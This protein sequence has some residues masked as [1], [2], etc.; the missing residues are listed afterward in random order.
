MTNLLEKNLKF[1][2]KY[3][4]ELAGKILNHADLS[5][6]YEI[7]MSQSGD[8][9]IFKDSVPVDDAIDPIWSS[10]ELYSSMKDKSKKSIT[11]ILG[12][13]MGYTF[14]EFAKRYKGK[15]ILHEPNLDFLRIAFEFVDFSEELSKNNIII[16]NNS[17]DVVKAFHSLYYRGYK[18][19]FIASDYYKK[20]DIENLQKIKTE[21][22]KIYVTF[23]QTHNNL[24]NK[25]N[26]W[27]ALLFN[28]IVDIINNQDL[29]VLK[30]KFKNKTAVIISAGPSLDKNIE[31]L[32]PYRDKLIIFCVGVAFKTAVKHGIIP[33]FVSVVDN[34]KE[35]IDIPELKQVNLIVTTSINKNI[36]ELS[37]KRLYNYHIKNIPAC[38]WLGKILGVPDINEYDAAGTVA[39]NCL[40]S[41]K[42]LG[43]NKII[44]IGQDLAYTDNKCYSQ[45][46]LYAGFN[47]NQD[48]SIEFK[49]ES[50][51]TKDFINNHVKILEKDLV[52]VK[53]LDG[54]NLLTRPDYYMFKLF[55]E[56]IAK[57]LS[58]ELKLINATEGG[59]YLEGYDHITLN[60]ALEKYTTDDN[61]EPEEILINSELNLHEKAKRKK[62]FLKELDT[63]I[64]NYS[65]LKKIIISNFK[66]GFEPYFNSDHFKGYNKAELTKQIL[67]IYK[68]LAE[69]SKL[70][71][72]EHTSF[73]EIWELY[74]KTK[75]DIKAEIKKLFED[76]PELFAE[77]LKKLKDKYLLVRQLININ[78]YH[79]FSYYT[80]ILFINKLISDFDNT[81][82]EL[83][84]LSYFLNSLFYNL[85]YYSVIFDEK[86]EYLK[87]TLE[88]TQ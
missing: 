51:Q 72:I 22:N 67:I 33:D 3:N 56:N 43:C 17:D 74:L 84:E 44:F 25:N 52:Y 14:K 68:M 59:A 49:G 2:S 11:I 77:N 9:I 42:I 66:Q 58:S 48:K 28:N 15:L 16:T 63:M 4:P 5:A 85:Y 61:V 78:P 57:T 7:N 80:T 26:Q 54:S 39:I 81:D 79:K 41:A 75:T 46:S 86:I 50:N 76:K 83:L 70:T 62:R 53:G 47:V 87:N 38:S 73:N 36:Y 37:P 6:N 19:N 13:G 31:N 64:K 71:E 45:S 40:Y 65:E 60:E 29:H 30:D 1:L 82:E 55:F 32:K 18:Y 12:M 20:Y 88:K 10:L 24:W 8:N 23:E 35:V 27:T 21:F 34:D 69:P